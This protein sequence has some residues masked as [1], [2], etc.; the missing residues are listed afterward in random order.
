MSDY[1]DALKIDADSSDERL[2]AAV[3]LLSSAIGV[4]VLNNAVALRAMRTHLRCEVFDRTQATHR[5]ENEYAVLVENAQRM[6]DH[7]RIGRLLPARPRRW[8][9]VDDRAAGVVELWSGD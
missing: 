6:L 1:R 8:V 3:Q 9:V 5:C 7:S 4:V 2:E